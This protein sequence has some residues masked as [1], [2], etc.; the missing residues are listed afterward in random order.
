M[1][2][3]FL[4]PCKGN[5]LWNKVEDTI[6]FKN[7]LSSFTPEKN[8]QFIILIGHDHDDIFYSNKKHQKRFC[9]LFPRF[10][11]RFIEFSSEIR[12]GHLTRMWNILYKEA[13]CDTSHFINYFY[14]CGDDIL[15]KTSGWVEKSILSIQSF[16]DVAICGP[17]NEHPSLL[18]QVMVSRTHFQIFNYLF[19]EYIF[20]W[21][22]DDWINLV[23]AP[24]RIIKLENHYCIN[25][26]GPPRYDTSKYDIKALKKK[27][28]EKA[29]QE[30]KKI[31][32]FLIK[33]I[34]IT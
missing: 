7:T 22:C 31:D 6:L 23:Y 9:Q 32:T 29:N 21:G 12:K 26:G 13:L 33:K 34:H 25:S 15:F 17:K 16:D 24:S 20:N 18:T 27:V 28:A 4:I 3:A 2:I 5:P 1:K 30:R 10:I 8:Y 19:P 14:Q 11:F